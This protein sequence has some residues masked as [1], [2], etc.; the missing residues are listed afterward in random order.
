MLFKMMV[1]LSLCKKFINNLAVSL[2]IHLSAHK[3]RIESRGGTVTLVKLK[4]ISQVQTFK[5]RA[6]NPFLPQ[7]NQ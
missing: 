3:T 6:N 4:S 5:S 1:M 2:P 7:L